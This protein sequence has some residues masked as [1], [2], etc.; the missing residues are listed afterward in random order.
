MP[1][2]PSCRTCSTSISTHLKSHSGVDRSPQQCLEHG[3]SASTGHV[4]LLT[5]HN[6]TS[7]IKRSCTQ[8]RIFRLEVPITTLYRSHISGMPFLQLQHYLRAHIADIP[9]FPNSVMLV[10]FST[11]RSISRPA[12]FQ[13]PGVVESQESRGQFHR[14]IKD[15]LVPYTYKQSG[16]GARRC[17]RDHT[18]HIG[19]MPSLKR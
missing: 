6:R 3:S 14:M 13:H 11:S 5:S 16:F 10:L 17:Q 2:N 7:P 19:M 18:S 4:I 8:A 15:A 1:I 9:D 12:R